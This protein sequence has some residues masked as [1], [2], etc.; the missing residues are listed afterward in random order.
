MSCHSLSYLL[1]NLFSRQGGY[2]T[3]SREEN[4]GYINKMQWDLDSFKYALDIALKYG[5]SEPK[6]DMQITILVFL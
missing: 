5:K 4:V 1:W 3:L 2:L 6:I